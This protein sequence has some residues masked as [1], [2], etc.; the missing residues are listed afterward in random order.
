MSNS[1][2]TVPVAVNEPVKAYAAGSPERDSLLSTYKQMYNQAPIDI[3]MYIGAE[4][5]FT[6][7]KKR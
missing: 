1:I 4:K 5:V 3:P 7:N 6:S 2:S